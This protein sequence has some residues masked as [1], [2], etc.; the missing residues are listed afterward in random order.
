ML[1]FPPAEGR[2]NDPE[3]LNVAVNVTVTPS[4]IDAICAKAK[5]TASFV[6]PAL[7]VASTGLAI[8]VAVIARVP[9]ALVEVKLPCPI[10]R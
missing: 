8:V 2:E 6:I 9:S 5:G 4:E 3:P 7:I 10:I 1:S